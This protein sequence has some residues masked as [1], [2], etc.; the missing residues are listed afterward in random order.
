MSL[1]SYL[2]FDARDRFLGSKVFSQ[3]PPYIVPT[4]VGIAVCFVAWR[5]LQEH[6]VA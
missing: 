6:T 5:Q 4:R 2:L 3:P 1:Q